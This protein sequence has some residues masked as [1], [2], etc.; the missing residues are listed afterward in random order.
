[1]NTFAGLLI[2][3][4]LIFLLRRLWVRLRLSRAKHPSLRGHARWSRR[5]ARLVPFFSYD[6]KRFY[7]CDGAPVGIVEQRRASFAALAGKL[8]QLAPESIAFSASLADSIPDVSFTNAYRVPFPFRTHVRKHLKLGAVVDATEGVRVRDIDGN[9]YMDLTGAYGVNVFGYDFY[10]ACMDEGWERA[11]S[12]GPVLGPYHPVIRDNVERLKAISGM[13][14]ISFHMSGTE[15]V[16]Q[17]V[18]M[19]RYHTGRSHLVMLCGAYHGWWDGVQP[20]VGGERKTSDVYMLRD[21]HEATLKVLET[22]HDIACVLINPL[23]AL[24]PNAGAASDGSLIA[25]DRNAGLDRE[26]YSAW[27][28]Q[29][30]DVCTR[31]GIVLIMDEVFTG[32]RLGYRGAQEY[33][34]VRGDLVTYGKTLGGGLPIGV[35]CGSHALMKRYDDERPLNINFARGTFNSHPFVMTAMDAFLQRVE[36]PEV[37]SQYAGLE[38]QWNDRV[39]RLNRRLEEEG[40]PVR[41][42]HLVSIWTVLYTEPSRYNWLFQYHL[43]SEGVAL[44]WVGSGRIIMSHNFSDAEFDELV[45]RFVRA[46]KAMRDGGWWW[47]GPGLTNKAIKRQVLKEMLATRLPWLARFWRDPLPLSK[48]SL[49]TA[50]QNEAVGGDA[51]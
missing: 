28:K 50:P 29:I 38:T 47:Q 14:E 13:D 40:L 7:A 43:R 20:G 33:F 4:G 30:R 17:A 21:M 26:A 16:M 11:R 41:I 19:A 1:M 10:K 32:F 42:A 31:R 46:G 37:Q 6:E 24:H 35:L 27:L 51:P 22:R 39:A 23:Q 5:F 9:W 18:R 2:L 34:G 44:S 15:A 45:E 36:A 3:A 25:S 8:A 12:L 49:N 48:P